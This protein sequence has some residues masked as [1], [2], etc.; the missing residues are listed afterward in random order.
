M[1]NAADKEIYPELAGID[2]S[3]PELKADDLRYFFAAIHRLSGILLKPTKAELVKTRIRARLGQMGF[4][5]YHEYRKYLET[6]PADHDE[7]QVFINLLTTNK[8]GFFRESGHFDDLVERILPV[9]QEQGRRKL[10]VWSAA[11]ST[12]EEAYTLA[13]VLDRH[14]PKNFSYHIHATDID[15]EVLQVASN[16]VYTK[17]HAEDI[18]QSYH[19][20]LDVGH[21]DIEGWL[22]IKKRLKERISFYQH[23]LIEPGGPSDVKFDIIFC[24]NVFIYFSPETVSFVANKLYDLTQAHGF[25]VV[26]HSETLQ[27]I[28]HSWLLR[29]A[30]VFQKA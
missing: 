5:S 6:L 10:E 4:E 3:A 20:C 14:L 28:E 2:S 22:R 15:S 1:A 17:A 24:R 9:W 11:S 21:G 7:W 23:N 8:T 16:G 27:G 12:G 29:G 25:L 13:M 26:S 30:S 18:P 19:N